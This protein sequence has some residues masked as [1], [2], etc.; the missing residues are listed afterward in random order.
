MEDR[1]DGFARLKR[2][3]AEGALSDAEYEAE[4]ARLMGGSGSPRQGSWQDR[5]R[6]GRE[7]TR[8]MRRWMRWSFVGAALVVVLIGVWFFG[9]AYSLAEARGE[10]GDEASAQASREGGHLFGSQSP[11]TIQTTTDPMTDATVRQAIATFEGARFNVEVAIA[12][13][14]GGDITYNATTFDKE[15]QPA[16]MRTEIGYNGGTTIPFQMR[17]DEN[18][19]LSWSSYNPQYSNQIVLKSDPVAPLYSDGSGG[20][21]AEQMAGAVNV[22]LRLFMTSGEETIKWPQGDASF[23]NVVEPCLAERQATREKLTRERE[24]AEH[25]QEQE[26]RERSRA[27]AD[28]VVDANAV[29]VNAM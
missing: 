27:M 28:G 12:C 24:E 17:A 8:D 3:H 11:W 10:L 22:T 18:P 25:V 21:N 15:G 9:K 16:E 7:A 2:L 14:T 26:E 1:V 13:S 6:E 20:D 5:W 4:K 29:G 19:A 23:R